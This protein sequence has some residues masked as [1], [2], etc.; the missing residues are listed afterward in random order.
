MAEI[1][2]W[3]FLILLSGFSR[4]DFMA[5]PRVKPEAVLRGDNCSNKA[6]VRC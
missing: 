6:G 1:P 2:V 3:R 4:P 5:A